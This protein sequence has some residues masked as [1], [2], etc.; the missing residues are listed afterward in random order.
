MQNQLSDDMKEAIDQGAATIEA[1]RDQVVRFADEATA[2]GRDALGQL[3]RAIQAHPLKAVA[4]A[5]GLGWL[6]LFGRP[7]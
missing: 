1:A 6:G 4:I 5:F 3:S 7:R 2:R